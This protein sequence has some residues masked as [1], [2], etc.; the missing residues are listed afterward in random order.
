MLYWVYRNI[1]GLIWLAIDVLG[2]GI[3]CIVIVLS[4]VWII[5][6]IYNEVKNKG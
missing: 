5:R 2:I 4:L 1:I 3:V 6:Q